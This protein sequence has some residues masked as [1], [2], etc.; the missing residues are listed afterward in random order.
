M[1][2]LWTDNEPVTPLSSRCYKLWHVLL[3]STVAFA[4]AY[5]TFV[6]LERP[7]VG[8]TEVPMDLSCEEDER[9]GF[10]QTGTPPYDLGCVQ[11]E[12]G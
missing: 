10:V 8:T 1:T 11:I 12:H 3:A 5:L 2:R 4:A 6:P 7:M 9:I